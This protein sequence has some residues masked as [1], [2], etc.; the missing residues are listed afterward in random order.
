MLIDPAGRLEIGSA[1]AAGHPH[2]WTARLCRCVT[3]VYPPQPHGRFARSVASQRWNPKGSRIFAC[4]G[5]LLASPWTHRPGVWSAPACHRCVLNRR[6]FPGPRQQNQ[7][8]RHHPPQKSFALSTPYRLRD[9]RMALAI[10]LHQRLREDTGP[11]LSS[12][13]PI[14]PAERSPEDLCHLGKLRARSSAFPRCLPMA[15][16]ATS[17]GHSQRNTVKIPN[18]SAAMILRTLNS[19]FEPKA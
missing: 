16:D 7:R 4:C 14:Q 11:R 19:K 8:P 6:R 2:C 9:P 12:S 18:G 13:H 17:A 15:T 5:H 3:C 1:D 10:V